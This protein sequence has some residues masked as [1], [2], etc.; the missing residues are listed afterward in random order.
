MSVDVYIYFG[1]TIV[2]PTRLINE[3][4]NFY[5]CSSISCKN[6]NKSAKITDKFCPKCGALNAKRIIEKSVALQPYNEDAVK[7]YDYWYNLFINNTVDE[8]IFYIPNFDLDKKGIF[9]VYDSEKYSQ[10]DFDLGSIDFKENLSKFNDLSETK[11]LFDLL[12]RFYSEDEIVISYQL[13][14]YC[15]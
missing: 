9:S 11:E 12:K 14:K 2:V 13:L 10:F 8:R 1:P 15:Y 3:P 7:D 4:H 5:A 6:Y